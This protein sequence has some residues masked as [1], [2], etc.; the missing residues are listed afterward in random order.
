MSSVAKE[1]SMT[2]QHRK[3]AALL[4][5]R[6]ALVFAISLMVGLVAGALVFWTASSVPMS[7]LTVGGATGGAIRLFHSIVDEGHDR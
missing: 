2:R 5:V 6:A 1:A 4:T 3:A 7:L